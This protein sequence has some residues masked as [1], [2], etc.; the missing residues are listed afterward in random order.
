MEVGGCGMVDPE[1]YRQVGYDKY[2]VTGF[3]F[4]FGIDRMAML[5]HGVGDIKLLFENDVRLL[6]QFR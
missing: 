6:R 4:G 5:R 3:A 1:V 2:D